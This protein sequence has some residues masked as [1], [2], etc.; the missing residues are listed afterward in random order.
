VNQEIKQQLKIFADHLKHSRRLSPHTVRAYERDVASLISFLVQKQQW[1]AEQVRLDPIK[2][3][4]LRM[5]VSHLFAQ[6]KHAKTT[7]R[8]VSGLKTFFGFAL[9]QGWVS[10]DPTVGLDSVKVPAHTPSVPSQQALQAFFQQGVE[11]QKFSTRDW[12]MFEL[13]YG[14]GLRVSE[15]V[16]LD[17]AH[18]DVTHRRVT[19]RE[20]K[21]RKDRVVPCSEYAVEAWQRYQSERKGPK[22]EQA[23]LLNHR[24]KRMTTRGVRYLLQKY[25]P[26]LPMGLTVSPHSFRHAFATHLLNHGADL[27]SIQQ[28]LGH[29]NL[30]TTQKYTQV[31]KEKLKTVYKDTHPR[32]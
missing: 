8:R 19:V 16:A 30:A 26:L 31:S 5:F 32:S 28:L 11:D 13:L 1:P 17:M 6:K 2:L 27:R 23:L 9:D 4:D 12:L 18:L 22:A 7:A 3:D 14:S 29:E 15:L 20:G 21:G 10:A 25:Q 24:G